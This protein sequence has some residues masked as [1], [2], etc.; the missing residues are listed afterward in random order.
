MSRALGVALLA[1]AAA[2]HAQSAPEVNA[3]RTEAA[4][5]AVT[6]ALLVANLVKNC[7]RFRGELEP[8]PEAVLAGWRERNGA[9]LAASQ[10]YFIFARAAMV[11]QG[12]EAA[13][14]RFDRRTQDVFV[15]EAN[16]SLNDIFEHASPQP[17]T[18]RRWIKAIADGEADL[19]WESKYAATLDELVE[20]ARSVQP[21]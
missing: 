5:Y 9:R 8:D 7:Q 20:F 21:R 1:I 6:H 19:N 15:D 3:Q 16:N 14:E 13:A 4:G 17:W 11:R 12:G 18:C 10:T 2:A